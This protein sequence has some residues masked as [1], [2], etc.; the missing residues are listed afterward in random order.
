MDHNPFDTSLP[1][2][3]GRQGRIT[4]A[5]LNA[6][7]NELTQRCEVQ[8]KLH[9]EAWRLQKKEL[10]ERRYQAALKKEASENYFIPPNVRQIWEKRDDERF[11]YL[12]GFDQLLE[13]RTLDEYLRGRRAWERRHQVREATLNVTIEPRLEV[14]RLT[15]KQIWALCVALFLMVV[16]IPAAAHSGIGGLLVLLCLP[17]AWAVIT[18]L[19]LIASGT[20]SG[21]GSRGNAV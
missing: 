18:M 10:H 8:R 21:P 9:D 19:P 16:G 13:L 15:G 2:Q 4:L 11:A 7:V 20:F 6:Q 17:L 1:S 14:R 5:S 12:T 3:A